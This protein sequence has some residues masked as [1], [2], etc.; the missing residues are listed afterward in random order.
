MSA[1]LSLSENGIG[2][3]V[4]S[5]VSRM[6]PSLR[7]AVTALARELTDRTCY[8]PSC[9]SDAAVRDALI[10]ALGQMLDRV[11]FYYRHAEAF[12]QLAVSPPQ[13]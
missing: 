11:S 13:Q 7:P 3:V 2:P 1:K 10:R 8:M 12:R 4:A 6:D 9:R 5:M